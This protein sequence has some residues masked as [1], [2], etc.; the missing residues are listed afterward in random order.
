MEETESLVSLAHKMAVAMSSAVPGSGAEEI[1]DILTEAHKLMGLAREEKTQA[2]RDKQTRENAIEAAKQQQ[3]NHSHISEMQQQFAMSEE[4]YIQAMVESQQTL[5]T[6]AAERNA[7]LQLAS[8]LEEH[9]R[10]QAERE[11]D[12]VAVLA[13]KSQALDKAQGDIQRLRA[14]QGKE[15]GHVQH[16]K[17]QVAELKAKLQ[18]YNAFD[19]ALEAY[20]EDSTSEDSDA[21]AEDDEDEDEVHMGGELDSPQAGSEEGKTGV[22]GW[23]SGLFRFRN[24]AGNEQEHEDGQQGPSQGY[25][26]QA[27]SSH[28]A[29]SSRSRRSV[30]SADSAEEQRLST[31]RTSEAGL[32]VPADPVDADFEASQD[33]Q[34]VVR[35]KAKLAALD[36]KEE[37]APRG[38]KEKKGGEEDKPKKKSKGKGKPK[39]RT[40]PGVLPGDSKPK[41]QPKATDDEVH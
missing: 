4:G 9:S 30:D 21:E 29:S 13:E 25:P 36:G 37:G 18:Q 1:K 39:M 5:A 16:L 8:K 40:P 6:A 27:S 41:A 20:G 31:P 23:F 17:S 26:S 33:Q 11:G 28:G 34:D 38:T 35:F 22:K 3:D 15:K 19:A 12:L 24:S 14:D 2:E 32:H 7:L 10:L